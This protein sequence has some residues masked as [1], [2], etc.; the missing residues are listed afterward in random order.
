M[1]FLQLPPL[2]TKSPSAQSLKISTTASWI[3]EFQSLTSQNL[4]SSDV[5]KPAEICVLISVH[6]YIFRWFKVDTTWYVP[7]RM[8]KETKYNF[9]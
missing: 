9:F 3:F 4:M 8:F 2:N 7:K 1:Q 6:P 5:D